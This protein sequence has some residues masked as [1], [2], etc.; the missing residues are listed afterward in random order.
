MHKIYTYLIGW[1]KH[2]K[3]Y[4]GLRFSKKARG[5]DIWQSYF[6]SSKY[7]REFRKTYGEPD[8]VEVRKTFA[9]VEHASLWESKVLTRMDVIHSPRWLNKTN[10]KAIR[11]ETQRK[12]LSGWNKG[13]KCP[14]SKESIEKQRMTMIGSVRGPYKNFNYESSKTVPVIFR[15]VEYASISKAKEHTGASFY[16][17]KKTATKLRRIPSPSQEL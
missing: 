7:V 11:G 9:D 16:T 14:R 1:S 8:V 13:L 12:Y 10:N 2:D 4:Y 17:I 5:Y 3:W 6:T 15:G